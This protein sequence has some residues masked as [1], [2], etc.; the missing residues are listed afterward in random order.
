[1]EKSPVSVEEIEKYGQHHPNTTSSQPINPPAVASHLQNHFH[2]LH[3]CLMLNI[4]KAVLASAQNGLKSGEERTEKK[5]IY[6]NGSIHAL[7]LA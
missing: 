5:N 2:S 6:C 4:R 3:P 1:L 7:N